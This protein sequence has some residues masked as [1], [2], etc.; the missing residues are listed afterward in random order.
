MFLVL[1]R[2]FFP[3]VSAQTTKLTVGNGAQRI[4]CSVVRP[5]VLIFYQNILQFFYG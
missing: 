4:S 2:K 1:S 3:I 5:V